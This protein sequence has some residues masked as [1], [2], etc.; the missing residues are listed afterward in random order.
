MAGSLRAPALRELQSVLV[1]DAPVVARG[2]RAAVGADGM[3][4]AAGARD[5][6]VEQRVLLAVHAH[7]DEVEHVARRGAL[8]PELVA[9]RRPEHRLAAPERLAERLAVGIAHE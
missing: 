3:A 1:H 9:R 7:V 8:V 5:H 4:H 6:A 2:P